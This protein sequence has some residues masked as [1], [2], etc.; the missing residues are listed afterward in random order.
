MKKLRLG[1][2]GTG[3]MG[4]AHI[5]SAKAAK[6]VEL[7]AVCDIKKDVADAV[8][9]EHDVPVFYN[10]HDLFKSGLIDAVMIV[11]PHY[12]HT[13]VAIDAFAAGYHVISDKPVAVHKADGMR[14]LEAQKA[15]SKKFGVMFQLRTSPANQKFKKLLESGELGEIKRINWIVTTWLR[16]QKYFDSGDWRASWRGEGGGVLLNQC[17]HQLDLFQWF[18]GMPNKVTAFCHLGKYHDIEVED[19]VTS[20][21]EFQDGKTAVFITSTGEAPGTNRLE[22]VCD[23][24]RLVLDEGVL[25]FKRTE[26]SVSEIIAKS[27]ETIPAVPIWDVSIPT[28]SNDISGTEVFEKFANAVLNDQEPLV[29]GA[30][31]LN[32]LELG[33]AM[34]LSSWLKKEVVLPIDAELYERE[35]MKLVKTSRYNPA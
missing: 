10:H 8:G 3:G 27:S 13:T 26:S 23:R 22:V 12:A 6:N 35:L 29:S 30:D 11:T 7:T 31:A 14:M 2:V 21:M 32:G 28:A 25:T 1:F 33:N 9:K 5:Q 15:A 16:T 18:F 17:P 20:Y 34:M 24:G 19:E 4:K